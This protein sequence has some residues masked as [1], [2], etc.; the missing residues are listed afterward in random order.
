MVLR[1][2]KRC[3]CGVRGPYPGYAQ[4][5]KP[6]RG[7]Q[8]VT[9]SRQSAAN[10]LILPKVRAEN[11]VLAALG[12]PS[13]AVVR[14]RDCTGN[15]PARPQGSGSRIHRVKTDTSL[16]FFQVLSHRRVRVF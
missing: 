3:L 2:A 1:W 6:R 16:A 12:E 5:F 7:W 4:K 14:E 15:D 13:S 9:W 11:D 8:Q 10:G